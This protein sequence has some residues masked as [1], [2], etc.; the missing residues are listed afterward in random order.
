VTM[1]TADKVMIT[2]DDGEIVQVT[3]DQLVEAP[4]AP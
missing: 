2:T 4:A 1:R 3:P